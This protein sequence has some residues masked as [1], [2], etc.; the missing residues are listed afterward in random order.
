MSTLATR[1]RQ[2]P[3]SAQHSCASSHDLSLSFKPFFRCQPSSG[4]ARIC[5][6]DGQSWKLGYGALTA[7]F[8]AGCSS[9]SMTNSVVTN[10]VLVE[11]AVSCWHLHQLISQTTQYLDSWISDL[12]Q[13]E[14]KVKLL[15]VDWGVRAP[16]PHIWRRH[17]N[18]VLFQSS[19][20]SLC[21]HLSVQDLF[22]QSTIVHPQDVPE[23]YVTVGSN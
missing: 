9:C 10:A 16:V 14:L 2:S 8:R 21:V 20:P 4:V 13:S 15:R 11:R 23:P 3:L 6:E 5:C 19:W 17:C 7:D 1:G 22:Q 18:P 12:L